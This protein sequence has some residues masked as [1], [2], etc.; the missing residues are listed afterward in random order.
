MPDA[1]GARTPV[2][3]SMPAPQKA[4]PT[5]LIYEPNDAEFI[6]IKPVFI[7]NS[8]TAYDIDLSEFRSDWDF[9]LTTM[10]TDF[11]ATSCSI[12]F[13]GCVGACDCAVHTIYNE[14]SAT[15]CKGGGQGAG[16]C[17]ARVH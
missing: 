8:N 14:D 1:S 2:V 16:G 4:D 5:V 12:T 9:T 7:G 6:P 10:H 15:F 3:V 17:R 11:F 13:E